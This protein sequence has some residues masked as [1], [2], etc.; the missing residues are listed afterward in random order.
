MTSD[1]ERMAT[2]TLLAALHARKVAQEAR[3]VV[4][5][6]ERVARE[7]AT[8]TETGPGR[9]NSDTGGADAAGDGSEA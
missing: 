2:T 1:R 9:P 4:A 6:G 3:A 5:E 7:A 8:A